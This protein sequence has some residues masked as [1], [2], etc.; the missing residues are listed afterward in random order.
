MGE[1]SCKQD[2]DP[3]FDD[4]RPFILARAIMSLRR[5]TC[6]LQQGLEVGVK[7]HRDKV[8]CCPSDGVSEKVPNG[9]VFGAPLKLGETLTSC[10]REIWILTLII[11]VVLCEFACGTWVKWYI[12]HAKWQ[13]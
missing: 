13:Y 10:F 12:D 4:P 6:A 11:F 5:T 1:R 9:V 8:P 7:S 3:S 2:M